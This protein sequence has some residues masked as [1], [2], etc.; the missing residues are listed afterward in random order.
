MIN[1]WMINVSGC[2]TVYVW[3]HFQSVKTDRFLETLWKSLSAVYKCFTLWQHGSQWVYRLQWQWVHW[4]NPFCNVSSTL[5]NW[6][7]PTSNTAL[8]TQ[9]LNIVEWMINHL[10]DCTQK[11][12]LTIWTL[13]WY[14]CRALDDNVQCS[15]DCRQLKMF[16]VHGPPSNY[17]KSMIMSKNWQFFSFVTHFTPY[18]S[19]VKS[20]TV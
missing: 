15:S 10:L 8:W 20:H 5:S 3:V 19:Y 17:C 9:Y 12:G 1:A 11:L 6:Y 18:I 14:Q 13:R 2:W 4:R 7:A 16:W